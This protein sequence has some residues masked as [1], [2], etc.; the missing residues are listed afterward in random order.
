MPEIR[1]LFFRLHGRIIGI[2]C[3]QTQKPIVHPVSYTHLDV[4]KRQD[5]MNLTAL[6]SLQGNGIELYSHIV[7]TKAEV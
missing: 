5:L 7:D 2:I 4:Y 3:I 1:M 6:A